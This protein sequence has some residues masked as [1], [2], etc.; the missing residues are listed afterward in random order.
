MQRRI[1]YIFSFVCVIISLVACS[2]GNSPAQ[3]PVQQS[4]SVSVSV[5][6]TPTTPAVP[7]GT[8]L[9]RA[10]WSHGLDGWQ[11]PK[12]WSVVGGQ[13]ETN[14]LTSTSIVVPFRPAVAN[15]A[16]ETRVQFAR[17]LVNVHN[18]F[19]IYADDQP[20]KDGYEAQMYQFALREPSLPPPGYIDIATDKLDMHAGFQQLDFVPAS[21]WHTYRI[22]VQGNQAT[23]F[24]DGTR[25]SR[26]TSTLNALSNGPFGL[27]SAGFA[28][29]VSSFTITA[30]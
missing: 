9:Y 11:G 2:A 8:V 25:V 5:Q 28:L 16:I 29:R 18:G 3:A 10:N 1:L 17:V 15:Y 26:S 14:S 27:Q 7:T 20:G 30:M 24:V 22:E 19:T 4:P 23:L 21:I 13:L 6:A 12:A